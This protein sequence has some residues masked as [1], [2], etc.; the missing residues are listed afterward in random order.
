[1]VESQFRNSTRKL[2]DSDEE[3]AL[4]EQLIDERAKA[5]IPRGFDGVH[6]L[7]FTPFRH[8]PLRH[9]SRFGTRSE[10]GI[11]YGAKELPTGFAE[12][13]YYRF[14]FLEGTTAD[15]GE[16][17]TQ[18][19]AFRFGIAA[20]RAIDLTQAPFDA[21]EAQLASKTDYT[22]SQRIGAEMRAAGIQACLYT[23]ARAESRGTCVAVFDN[24]F[25]P[26]RPIPPEQA[27][28]CIA[29]RARVELRTRALLGTDERLV[30]LRTQFEVRRRLPVPAT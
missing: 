22:E 7:L 27:W 10:R 2:V 9:G 17:S 25:R 4:L 20:A 13:A 19:T 12:V 3:Q 23:S 28:D 15:L 26:K 29:S 18:L 8:P 24:V 16:V 21:F 14:V 5:P 6:Y 1:V 30:F 11:L